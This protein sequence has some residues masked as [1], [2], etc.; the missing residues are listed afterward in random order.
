MTPEQTFADLFDLLDKSAAEADALEQVVQRQTR[1]LEELRRQPKTA[2]ASAMDQA[3]L[4]KLATSLEQEQL[5]PVGMDAKQACEQITRNPNILIRWT[6]T[7]VTPLRETEGH[8]VKS[9]SAETEKISGDVKLVKIDGR[10]V[11]DDCG[12]S[13][14]LTP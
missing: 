2:S 5:L 4:M 9:A 7:L 13:E 3:S 8:G 12:W 11:K 10:L 1:E 6:Q 14:C